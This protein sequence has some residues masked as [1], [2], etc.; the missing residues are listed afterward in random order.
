MARR[1]DWAHA[2]L[3]AVVA[4]LAS[5]LVVASDAV[6][7]AGAS[8]GLIFGIYP[9]GVAGTVGPVASIAPEDP[10]RRLSALE[11]L[12]A[13]GRPFVLHLYASYVGPD[14]PSADE[15]VGRQVRAY[16]SVGFQTEVALCYRPHDGGSA[17]DVSGFAEFVRAAVRSLGR[18]RNFV[19]AQVTNEANVRGSSN[20]SDGYYTDAERALIQGVIAATAEI[21]ARGLTHVRVGFN[22]A[23][24]TGPDEQA[25]WRRLGHDGGRRFVQAVDWVGIDAYPGTW[26]PPLQAGEIRSATRRF[27]DA[28][29]SRLR[30]DYLPAAGIPRKVPLIV[31]ENG[32]PTGPGRSEASQVAV[33]EA[34]VEAVYRARTAYNITGYRWFDLRDANSSSLSF[35]SQYGI[36]RDDYSPKAA[37][38]VY[39][40]LVARLSAR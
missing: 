10:A 1:G 32:Y 40:E 15:Q 17:A 9:G 30:L 18:S 3:V 24:S 38:A 20:T 13:P 14:G 35:E 7:H 25:F 31:T 5:L 33:M 21:R 19:S 39:R 29:L 37:F 34:A 36:L 28:A 27:M 11:Q 4:L 8:P 6:A 22:W 26:G 12:R 2:A 16:G 23:Y